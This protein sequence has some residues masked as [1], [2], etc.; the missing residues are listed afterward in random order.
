MIIQFG[1]NENFACGPS[2]Y[3][4]DHPKFIVSNQKEV[5]ISVLRVKHANYFHS[6]SQRTANECSGEKVYTKRFV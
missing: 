2:L 5:S 1:V 3:T 4:M 6:L